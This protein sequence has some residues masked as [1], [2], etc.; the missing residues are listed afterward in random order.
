MFHITPMHGEDLLDVMAIELASHLEPWSELAFLTELELPQSRLLVARM[1]DSVD[2]TGGALE[3]GGED[4]REDGVESDGLTEITRT[5]SRDARP[6]PMGGPV[7]Y[8][9]FWN[10]AGEVQIHNLAVH[11]LHRRRGIG[12]A[13]LV[14]AL[15][16]AWGEGARK[17]VLEVR[18]GNLTARH[19][20]ESV[21]FEKWGER[22]N[23]YGVVKEAA[24]LMGMELKYG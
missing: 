20:Y 6:G 23:Y 11:P 18:Q 14:H 15:K 5:R 21:G 4:A 7:G 1:L 22:P 24:V 12:R 10:V 9:C 13:L 17:A 16:L 2:G 3:A 8:I 19:L